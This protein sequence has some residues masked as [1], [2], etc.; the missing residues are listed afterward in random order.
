M[1]LVYL[2]CGCSWMASQ[3]QFLVHLLVDKKCFELVLYSA[4]RCHSYICPVVEAGWHRSSS[5]WC[6]SLLIKNCLELVLYSATRCHSY[7]CPVVVAG[8]HRSSSSW[9]VPFHSQR[10]DSI[11]DRGPGRIRAIAAK[12]LRGVRQEEEGT[13]AERTGGRE[14]KRNWRKGKVSRLLQNKK[15]DPRY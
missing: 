6:I 8:W 11:V 13:Q 5:S 10:A 3:F 7:I 2:S 15:D 9:C 14:E 1:S 4:T 12:R